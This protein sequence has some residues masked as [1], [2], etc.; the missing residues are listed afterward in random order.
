MAAWRELGDVAGEGDSLQTLAHLWWCAGEGVRAQDLAV[1]A[2]DLLEIQA[3]GPELARA[4]ATLAQL[5]MVGG[6]DHHA[7]VAVGERAVEL[8]GQLGEEQVVVHAL[9]TVGTAE[10][11][12]EVSSGW[13]KLEES[14][15]RARA[16]GLARRR[17]PG[18]REPR[19]RSQARPRLRAAE[20]HL[21]D[22]VRYT[23]VHDLDLLRE[24]ALAYA[25]EVALELGRWDDV[26]DVAS[27]ALE[28]GPIHANTARV[29]GAHGPRSP[30]G[31][32]RRPRPVGA[33]RRGARRRPPPERPA[34]RL[35]AAGGAGRGG[36]AGGRP[37][38]RRRPRPRPGSRSCSAMPARGGG[39][40]WRSGAGRRRARHRPPDG[41]AEP[42][43]LQMDG[44][45]QPRP[46][47]R[48]PPSAARTSRRSP[49]PTAPTRTSCAS[50]LATL[51]HPRRRARRPR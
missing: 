46:P 29:A 16:A 44:R 20:H 43:R 6:H 50:A 47:P 37:L 45:R 19:R 26:E 36:L 27:T 13:A 21:A 11:C 23:T 24:F 42:Y 40:S 8:G 3:P 31:P 9:N 14:L 33:A 22:A 17:R 28:R 15:Q 2:V 25:A 51:P 39:G 41:C 12:M 18:P 48:G 4:Y 1:G 35:P 30:S 10:V 38:P 32:P 49:W 5:I 34:R 7:A